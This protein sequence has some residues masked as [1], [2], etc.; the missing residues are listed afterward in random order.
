MAII[1]DF[2]S[3]H[4][5]AKD[6]LDLVMAL[7][8]PINGHKLPRKIQTGANDLRTYTIYSTE[9]ILYYYRAALY[10]D[11]RINAYPDF[12]AMKQNYM[13]PQDYKPMP[14]HVFIDYLRHIGKFGAMNKFPRVMKGKQLEDWEDF[15]AKR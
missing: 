6:G 2:D 15:L 14:T 7:L 10:E 9:D 4:Q 8:Q 11:C 5:Q 13:I 1:V 12:E 3:L